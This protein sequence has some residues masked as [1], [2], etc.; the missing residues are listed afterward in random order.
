M[1]LYRRHHSLSRRE[2]DRKRAEEER[3]D[4]VFLLSL[5]SFPSLFISAPFPPL[6]M[7]PLSRS[8]SFLFSRLFSLFLR[9]THGT[10]WTEGEGRERNR[11]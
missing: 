4:D 2:K 3:K 10:S 8:P 5:S 9:G 1:I 11:K 6:P 7:V